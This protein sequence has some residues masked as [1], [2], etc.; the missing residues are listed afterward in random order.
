MD[1]QKFEKTIKDVKWVAIVLLILFSIVFVVNLS[2][3]ELTTL[4]VLINIA[5]LALLLITAIGCSKKLMYG[6]I[7]GIVVSILL[8]LS[9]DILSIIIGIC[10]LVECVNVIRYMKH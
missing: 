4:V 1:E 7:C 3:G 6:P 8:I 10:L 5:D 9:F 2:S